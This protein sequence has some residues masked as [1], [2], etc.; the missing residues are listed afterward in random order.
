M[1]LVMSRGASAWIGSDGALCGSGVYL[2]D[3]V[4]APALFP[5]R[6]GL[7]R[8]RGLGSLQLCLDDAAEVI[9]AAFVAVVC[10]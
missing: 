6:V 1:V 2:R 8:T 4:C 5:R 7:W 10:M 3:R 9:M